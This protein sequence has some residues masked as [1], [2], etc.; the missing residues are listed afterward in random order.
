M[1]GAISNI[2]VP[3]AETVAYGMLWFIAGMAV[4]TR[5][6]MERIEGFG[7]F[8]ASKLPYKPEPGMDEETA[9][10]Q[11]VA[12]DSAGEQVAENDGEEQ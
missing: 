1:Q 6:G 3:A 10:Q 12:P 5:Y 8:Y 2:P 9:M 11:A 7:R 4:P